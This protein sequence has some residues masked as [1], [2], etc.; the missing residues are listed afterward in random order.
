[1]VMLRYVIAVLALCNAGAALAADDDG[2]F[3]GLLRARDLTPFGFL[4]LDMRPAHAVAIE[5][6]S[7]VIENGT[8]LSEHMGF[9]S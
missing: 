6:G 1:M 5:R 7:F 4:R 8:R 3:Y 9:E 2:N